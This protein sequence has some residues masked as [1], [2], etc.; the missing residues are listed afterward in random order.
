[1]TSFSLFLAL[2]S[3]LGLIWA[4]I[5]TPKDEQ[6][7]SLNVGTWALIGAVV[8]GRISYVSVHWEYFQE[9]ILEIPKVW[10]GGVSWPGA[11]AGG[12]LATIIF[13]WLYDIS[14]GKFADRLIPLLASLSVAVW[15]GCWTTGCAYG[16]KLDWGLPA[17]D[18][19]GIWQNRLPLQLIGAISTIAVFWG[20]DRF[21]QQKEALFPGLAMSLGLGSLSLILFGVSI[22]RVDPYPVNNQLRLETWAT[23]FFLMIA[24]FCGFVAYFWNRN[25]K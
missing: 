8:G 12:I 10:L 13:A 4:V 25:Q 24:V 21:R 19:W 9:H 3:I 14:V 1:M 23:L 20:I 22:L 11:L 5:E 16:P 15:L 7:I 17:R 6:S 2:A 18:E